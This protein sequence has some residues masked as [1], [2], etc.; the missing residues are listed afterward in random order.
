MQSTISVQKCRYI[1][2]CIPIARQRLDKHIPTR[3]HMQ[4]KDLHCY[5]TDQ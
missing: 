2:T 4:Q 1:V 3:V 5:A